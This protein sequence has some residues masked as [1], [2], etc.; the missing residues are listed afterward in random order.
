MAG[1][2]SQFW[3]THGYFSEGRRWLHKVLT[4]TDTQNHERVDALTGA[5]WLAARHSD[6]NEAIKSYEQA[7]DI[8]REIDYKTGIAKAL[9]GLAFA[10]GFL[11]ADD[12]LIEALHSESLELWREVGDKRGIACRIG[13]RF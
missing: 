4:L 7:V 9:G 2:L 3:D 10:K 11:G 5:G 12:S 6:M 1:A 8:A 13:L